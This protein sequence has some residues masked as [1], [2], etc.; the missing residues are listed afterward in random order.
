M[1]TYEKVLY[2]QSIQG[3]YTQLMTN[4]N[5]YAFPASNIYTKEPTLSR[6]STSILDNASNHPS[7]NNLTPAG[8]PKY[9]L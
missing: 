5:Y 1:S 8:K 6:L 2:L 7:R 9:Q 3:N 4:M